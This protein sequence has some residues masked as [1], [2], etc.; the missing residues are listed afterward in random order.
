MDWKLWVELYLATGGVTVV[1]L[2]A[3]A[4]DEE[5]LVWYWLVVV[6]SWPAWC[7][8]LVIMGGHRLLTTPLPCR[9]LILARRA[10]RAAAYRA[11]LV[12]AV[13]ERERSAALE[14]LRVDTG[15]RVPPL[16]HD[17]VWMDER[18]IYYTPLQGPPCAWAPR[19]KRRQR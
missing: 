3:H 15:G 5:Y 19:R 8:G 1:L 7:I 14:E 12:A 17:K 6:L 16:A 13:S 10:E 2:W 9:K 18:G 4:L 11:G